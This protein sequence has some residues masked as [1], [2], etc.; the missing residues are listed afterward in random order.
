MNSPQPAPELVL[1]EDEEQGDVEAVVRRSG[2]SFFW[3]MRLL[4]EEKRAAMY[5]IYA[6]C[7]DV[8]DIADDPGIVDDK[9]RRLGGW[10]HDI[11]RV[12]H[13]QPKDA[14][15]RALVA[16]AERYGLRTRDFQAVIDGMEIDAAPRV[17]F[18]TMADLTWYCDR[19]ACAVGRLSVR[20]FGV[21]DEVGQ[22][23]AFAL[24]QALQ[25]TNI[26]RDLAED[27]Q[28][29]RLYV[30]ADVLAN[31][32]ITE[33]GIIG[34]VLAHPAFEK[35]CDDIG[36]VAIRRFADARELIAACDRNAVRPAVMMM[37][38]YRAILRRAMIRRWPRTGRP[39]SLS[40]LSKIYLVLRHGLR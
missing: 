10:R 3:A 30:P 6:F 8:D 16:P 4:P 12:F 1:A 11:E 40:K 36:A 34:D 2:T 33:T 24:G 18:Q 37:E 26:L 23:L 19:V 27:A 32:G 29:D 20:V 35:A 14:V 17:R 7:R 5:A 21:D 25:L 39:V 31:H 22:K 9:R 38:A 13:G 15:A 28:R